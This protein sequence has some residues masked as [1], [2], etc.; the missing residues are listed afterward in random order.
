MGQSTLVRLLQGFD[1][2]G[3]DEEA[4]RDDIKFIEATEDVSV[5]LESPK[6]PFD[7][8]GYR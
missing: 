7:L 1:D 4:G 5:T 6:E 3:R 8:V 2:K